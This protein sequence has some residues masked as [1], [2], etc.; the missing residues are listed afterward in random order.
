MSTKPVV[1]PVR[2]GSEPRAAVEATAKLLADLGH[3]VTERDPDYGR[4][5]FQALFGPRYLRGAYDDAARSERPEL[6]ERRTRGLAR[7][8]RLTTARQLAAA[9]R[10]AGPFTDQVLRLWDDHDV[11]L[12]PT[13]PRLPAKLHEQEGLGTVRMLATSSPFTAFCAAWNVTGQPAASVPAG[14]TGDDVPL[15]VQL[16]GRPGDEATLIALAAQ[17]EQARPWADRIPPCAR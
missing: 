1:Q 2:V 15:A 12:T 4:V 3:E 7:M 5:P 6:L 9:R 8:G 13:L 17:I 14:W 16:V 11:L 10:A